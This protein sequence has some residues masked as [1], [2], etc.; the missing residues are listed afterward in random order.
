MMALWT[1]EEKKHSGN[2]SCFPCSVTCLHSSNYLIQKKKD[3]DGF[4]QGNLNIFLQGI[5]DRLSTE[6]HYKGNECHPKKKKTDDNVPF[7]W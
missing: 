7:P 6:L 2:Y 5:K 3:D 1:T 4:K